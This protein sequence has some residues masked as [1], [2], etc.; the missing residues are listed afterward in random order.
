MKRPLRDRSSAREQISPFFVSFNAVRALN[1][2]DNVLT[3]LYWCIYFLEERSIGDAALLWDC[4]RGYA[5]RCENRLQKGQLD[6]IDIETRSIT[7]IEFL[8]DT[9]CRVRDAFKL[10]NAEFPRAFESRKRKLPMTCLQIVERRR[11][12]TRTGA[13]FGLAR[14]VLENNTFTDDLRA[15]DL[16]Y[17][18]LLPDIF[19][20]EDFGDGIWMYE[21]T[22]HGKNCDYRPVTAEQLLEDGEYP[23]GLA[24]QG[25]PV[26]WTYGVCHDCG[27]V[28]G[29]DLIHG[30]QLEK[31]YRRCDQD[32]QEMH[33][34]QPLRILRPE[35]SRP[36]SPKELANKFNCSWKTLKK[37]ID[38]G[39]VRALRL[40]TKSYRIHVED[41]PSNT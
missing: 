41:E 16:G 11:E 39:Q 35:W 2:F 18:L 4:A 20:T 38:A 1:E 30:E 23:Y 14:L 15:P 21:W 13:G 25:W 6:R 9:F 10:S 22:R 8:H 19:P 26:A 32:G 17:P 40:S 7:A 37:R 33:T 5:T 29:T 31:V 24:G 12:L 27:H 34:S 36:Y 28:I 3:S